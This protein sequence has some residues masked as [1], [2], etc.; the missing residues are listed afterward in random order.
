MSGS[1]YDS[2]VVSVPLCD[3]ASSG[4]KDL[5]RRKLDGF[6]NLKESEEKFEIFKL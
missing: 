5:G 1:S 6:E 4:S 3:F 2:E